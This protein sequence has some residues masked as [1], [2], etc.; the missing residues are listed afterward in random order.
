MGIHA[1]SITRLLEAQIVM[2]VKDLS[3]DINLE[4]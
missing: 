1:I 2:A 4:Y 3:K